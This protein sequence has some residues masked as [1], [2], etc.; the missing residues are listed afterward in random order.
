M[1]LNPLFAFLQLICLS[2]ISRL[3]KK[4]KIIEEKNVSPKKLTVSIL[5]ERTKVLVD[6][7]CRRQNVVVER[8]QG[9]SQ[10]LCS[11]LG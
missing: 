1:L 5:S 4:P 10:E 6:M 8:T 2:L 3:A 11:S 9:L 7:E